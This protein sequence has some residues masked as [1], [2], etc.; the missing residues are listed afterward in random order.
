MS[1]FGRVLRDV[2]AHGVECDRGRLIMCG[3][4][5]RVMRRQL[6]RIPQLLG[7]VAC[8]GVNN[9]KAINNDGFLQIQEGRSMII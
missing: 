5:L 1:F 9:E 2:F 3:V 4:V 6:V 7:A 8:V